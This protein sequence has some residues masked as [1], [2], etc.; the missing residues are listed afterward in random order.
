MTPEE[1][2]TIEA[3]QGRIIDA[4]EQIIAKA[5]HDADKAKPPKKNLRKAHADD[6]K[7]G[8]IVWHDNGDEGWFWN[9]VCEPCHYGDDFKAYVADDGSR[10][11][12]LGAWVTVSATTGK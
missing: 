11:G 6:I 3:E 4:A 1:Y 2:I 9:I 10:Y 7:P 5:R 12:L 8:K